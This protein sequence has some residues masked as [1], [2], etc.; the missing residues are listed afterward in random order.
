MS[1]HCCI[2]NYNEN[3]IHM[4]HEYQRGLVLVEK[5]TKIDFNIYIHIEEKGKHTPSLDGENRHVG[6]LLQS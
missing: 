6:Q 4:T 2:C 3:G 5:L 1:S